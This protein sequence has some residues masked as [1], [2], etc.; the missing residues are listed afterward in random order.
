M[1]YTELYISVLEQNRL[2]SSLHSVWGGLKHIRFKVN[3]E[4]AKMVRTAALKG[5]ALK[6]NKT[7]LCYEG[8]ASL[9]SSHL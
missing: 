1:G 9:G 2:L 3:L 5:T 8:T 7:H 4:L 6:A